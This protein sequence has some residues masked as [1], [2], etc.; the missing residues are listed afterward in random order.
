MENPLEKSEIESRVFTIRGLQVMLDSDLARLYQ[1]ETKSLNQA[2]KRNLK[3]FPESFRFKLTE[4]EFQILRSQIV[5]SSETHGGRRFLPYV[6]TEQGVSMLSATLKSSIAIAVSIEI[7]EAFVSMRKSQNQFIGVAQRIDGLE[8]KQLI[9]ENRL[10]KIFQVLAKHDF[11]SSGIFFEN[12]IF[13]AYVFSS[14]LVS[15]A[16]KSII[17]IDNYIDETTL[18]QLSK[19]NPK[20]RCTI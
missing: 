16:K 3:R 8:S 9:T 2:V 20:A 5:T 17:L 14:G 11:P 12:Q 13:D 7:I 19:R 1:V 15:R 10:D 18:L 4:N 6:F